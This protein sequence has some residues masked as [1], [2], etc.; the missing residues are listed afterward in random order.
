MVVKIRTNFRQKSERLSHAAIS[1]PQ[2]SKFGRNRYDR[3]EL[4]L[5][6]PWSES[7]RGGRV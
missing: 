4:V 2:A 6:L 5:T 3:Q 7:T 1:M